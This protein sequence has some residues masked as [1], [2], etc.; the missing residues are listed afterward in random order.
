ML[1]FAIF[2]KNYTGFINSISLQGKANSVGEI[3]AVHIA[4]HG[5][6]F[7]ILDELIVITKYYVK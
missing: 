4:L 3:P 5:L 2:F 1:M 6:S 7:L